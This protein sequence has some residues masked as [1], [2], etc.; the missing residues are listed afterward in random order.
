VSVEQFG[1]PKP[2]YKEKSMK[3]S[4]IL[5]LGLGF[6]LGCAI[7]G[8]TCGAEVD[9]Q[10]GRAG[11]SVDVRVGPPVRYARPVRLAVPATKVEIVRERQVPKYRVVEQPREPWI[12]RGVFGRDHVAI[13]KRTD[14]RIERIE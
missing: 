2:L 14:L 4:K 12:W 5:V 1:R 8:Y 9:V 11:V 3:M 6:L 10:V 13:P 7:A